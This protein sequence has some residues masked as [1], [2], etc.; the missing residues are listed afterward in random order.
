MLRFLV[1]TLTVVPGRWRL[2]GVPRL[3]ERPVGPLVDAL[4]RLGARIEY[5]AAEGYIPLRIEGGAW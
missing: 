4:R 1:A 2:D 5:L 3:R